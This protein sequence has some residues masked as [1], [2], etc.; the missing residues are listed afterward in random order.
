MKDLD[1]SILVNNVGIGGTGRFNECPAKSYW[2]KGIVNTVA[3]FMMTKL[4]FN[5][6]RAR[7]T[8]ARLLMSQAS[9]V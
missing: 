7:S 1:V 2:E 6:F 9:P 8:S 3:Q 4:F 5:H